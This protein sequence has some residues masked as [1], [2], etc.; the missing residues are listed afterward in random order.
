[1]REDIYVFYARE[2]RDPSEVMYQ[3]EAGVPGRRSARALTL[4][5]EEA[6]GSV[7]VFLGGRE[8]LMISEDDIVQGADGSLTMICRVREERKPSFRVCPALDKAPAGFETVSLSEDGALG[9][10][11]ALE[12]LANPVRVSLAEESP[13][14]AGKDMKA[15]LHLN[16]ISGEK[17]LT[18]ALLVL[19]YEGE[20][21]ELTQK[22]ES[23]RSDRRAADSFYTGQDWE[24]GLARFAMDGRADF[25][26]AVHPLF[27]DTEVFL[28][29]WPS[30]K[31]GCACRVN[32]CHTE[33]VFELPLG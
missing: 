23:L 6:L 33:A 19:S 14:D 3:I 8:R 27:P 30:M 7:K 28:E 22:E 26:L 21:A 11:R 4:T 18:E 29:K 9:E 1:M 16:G 2:G 31:D 13:A 15:S 17:G 25:E 10:Y 5:A 32:G 24:I 12:A 20:S